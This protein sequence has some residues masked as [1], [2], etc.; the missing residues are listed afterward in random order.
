MQ[1]LL[2]FAGELDARKISAD[3]HEVHEGSTFFRNDR[4]I[5]RF[6]QMN[7]PISKTNSIGNRLHLAAPFL[8]PWNARH[9]R[10]TPE[11]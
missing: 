5:C 8:Q 9:L 1:K 6:Q 3:D 11:R 10:D 7:R 4:R 2:K